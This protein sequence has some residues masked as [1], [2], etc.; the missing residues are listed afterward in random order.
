[1]PGIGLRD[2]YVRC[3]FADEH[4]LIPPGLGLVSHLYHIC[5]ILHRLSIGLHRHWFHRSH[6]WHTGSSGD[7][8]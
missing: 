2:R 5:T 3:V 7:L 1:M 4:K 8:V 6:C